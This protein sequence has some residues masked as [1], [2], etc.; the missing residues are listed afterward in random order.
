[1]DRIETGVF[2]LDELLAGGIPK[3]RMVL[4]SG[5]CGTGKSI[6]SNLGG[7]NNL[8]WIIAIINVILIVLIILVAVK[9][10]R[11]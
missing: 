3:G 5:A 7:G 8:I 9:L 11:R 4:D 1:M 10:S 6:F 2:G